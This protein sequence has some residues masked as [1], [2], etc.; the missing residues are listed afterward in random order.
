MNGITSY[1]DRF[2]IGLTGNIGTGKSIVRKMLQ[3]LGAY[4]ID[5]D[6]LAHEALTSGGSAPEEII[7]RFGI[8]VLDDS[9]KIDRSK[10]AHIVFNNERSLIDLE[11]ILHPLVSIATVNLIRRSHLPIIVIEAIK[12]LESDLVGLCDSIWVVDAHEEIIFERLASDRGIERGKIIERLSNQSS[13]HKKR[14]K[15]DVVIKNNQDLF[16]TWQL[17]LNEWE[18]LSTTNDSFCGFLDN[19]S[20]LTNTF[21]GRIVLPQ[22]NVF[23]E[24]EEFNNSTG[25]FSWL[26]KNGS[27]KY[28]LKKP[29]HQDLVR[30]ALT[31]FIFSFQSTQEIETITI[32]DLS[33]FDLTLNGYYLPNSSNLQ[34]DLQTVLRFVEE[35]GQIQLIQRINI[36]LDN[37]LKERVTSFRELGYNLVTAGDVRDPQWNKAGYNL[38]Q[39]NICE[40]FDLFS[41]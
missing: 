32:W 15:A 27:G 2:V 10:I 20:S 31:H 23:S 7:R 38:Y 37:H 4:G 1:Q 28:N 3:H 13:A 11:S 41:K 8:D 12:L 5:A 29:G 9:G 33:Q 17:V 35:F 24:I 19:S 36:P 18:K 14:Q 34:N 40:G 30:L 6:V 21:K 25:F 16:A 26:G 39:K 22:T